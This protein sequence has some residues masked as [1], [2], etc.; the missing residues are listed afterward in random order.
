MR[1]EQNPVILQIVRFGLPIVVAVF[2][3]TAAR[4]FAY[5]ADEA[6]STAD[7]SA[8]LLGRISAEVAVNQFSPFWSVL[9]ALGG[10]FGLDVL[11]T[12]KIM[13]LV[14]G[15]FALLALYLLGVEVLDDRILAFC[16]A[17][18]VALDPWLLQ[19]GP[20]GSGATSLLTLSLAT[21]FFIKREDYALA[22]LFAGLCTLI[23]T[24]SAV[25]FLCVLGEI[26]KGKRRNAGKII[27]ASGV[28]YVAVL[29]PWFVVAV[30]RDLPLL[31]QLRVPGGSVAVS[32]LNMV[33]VVTFLTIA[34]LGTT[35]LRR[36]PLLRFLSGGQPVWLWV[37]VAWTSVAGLLFARDFWLAGVPVLV[38]LAMQGVRIV[39]PALR[40][41]FPN[42]STA[43]IFTAVLLVLNQTNF[44]MVS[45]DVMARAIDDQRDV[46]AVARWIG[47]HMP[48]A[49]A[50]ETDQPGSLGYQLKTG[51]R[52][53]PLGSN[54]RAPIV[55]AARTAMAGYDELFRPAGA[56]ED[57]SAP[58]RD[59]LALFQRQSQEGRP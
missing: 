56:H 18:M 15:C 39:I 57:P 25:L 10:M 20:S 21:L 7:W 45:Q 1:R 32:W 31:P 13:S 34:A 40:E 58:R 42:Y 2:Y 16:A 44:L 24:P 55:L 33:P 38:V 59:G 26:W 14:F 9:V 3:A 28:L 49:V 6:F 36:S 17:L 27:A 43:F 11:L 22:T 19:M 23:A 51:V 12:A 52:V 8:C 29:L 37:W 35:V 50:I 30:V 5:T 41:E 46:A 47:V 4:G 48:V 54:P 53:L